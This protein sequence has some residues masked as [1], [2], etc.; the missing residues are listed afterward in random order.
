MSDID[1]LI[2]GSFVAVTLRIGTLS[3]VVS[4][5]RLHFHSVLSNLHHDA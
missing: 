2:V 5:Y 1:G 3:H 4:P